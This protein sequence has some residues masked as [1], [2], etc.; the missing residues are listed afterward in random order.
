MS[1]FCAE[2]T[3]QNIKVANWSKNHWYHWQEK[4]HYPQRTEITDVHKRQ[5][6]RFLTSGT[7]TTKKHELQLQSKKAW[8]SKQQTNPEF[9]TAILMHQA[10]ESK[11]AGHEMWNSTET[12]HIRQSPWRRTS[13]GAGRDLPYQQQTVASCSTL[14]MAEDANPALSWNREVKNVFDANKTLK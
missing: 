4:I 11:W 12:A 13:A 6:Y 14:L 8:K 2:E 5:C 9:H 7:V 10:T 1:P 3:A